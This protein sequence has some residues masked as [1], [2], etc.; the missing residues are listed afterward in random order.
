MATQLAAE[1][2]Y[3]S[4]AGQVLRAMVHQD[5]DLMQPNKAVRLSTAL[6]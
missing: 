4:L 5:V 6:S 1:A 2:K 3:A